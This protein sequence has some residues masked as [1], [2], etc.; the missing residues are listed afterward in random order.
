M[1]L[2]VEQINNFRNY[3][4]KDEIRFISEVSKKENYYI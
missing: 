2:S 4:V 3:K 1:P